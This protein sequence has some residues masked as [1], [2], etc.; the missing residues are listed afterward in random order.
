MCPLE[1]LFNSIQTIKSYEDSAEIIRV[2][3]HGLNK[4][5][6][7]N[8]QQVGKGKGV[9]VHQ[10]IQEQQKYSSIQK[11]IWL[12]GKELRGSNRRAGDGEEWRRL[13]RETRVQKGL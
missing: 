13:L 7:V 6:N 8:L 4:I 11:M 10:R 5:S 3:R 9:L 1:V 2:L 12:Y